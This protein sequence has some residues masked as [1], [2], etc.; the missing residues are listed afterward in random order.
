MQIHLTKEAYEKYAAK[1]NGAANVTVCRRR[2][3]EEASGG[4]L[5]YAEW[6]GCPAVYALDAYWKYE[7]NEQS[8][9]ITL[10]DC[11]GVFHAITVPRWRGTSTGRTAG[12]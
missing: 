12:S 1:E 6:H 5:A 11:V 7:Y 3:E 10:L 4:A 9:E 2:L 8:K